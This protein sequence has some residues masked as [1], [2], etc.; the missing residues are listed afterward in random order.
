MLNIRLRD[1]FNQK[2]TRWWT[3]FKLS[4]SLLRRLDDWLKS[5]GIS[6]SKESWSPSFVIG[7]DLII[8]TL[9]VCVNVKIIT[10]N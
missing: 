4:F 10:I 8:F 6:T 9:L 5:S 2:I 3:H 7:F 1:S